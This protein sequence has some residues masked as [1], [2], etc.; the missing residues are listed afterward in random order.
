MSRWDSH[1]YL[2]IAER[3]RNVDELKASSTKICGSSLYHAQHFHHLPLTL[4]PLPAGFVAGISDARLD[5][6]G[7]AIVILSAVAVRSVALAGFGLDSLI[8]IIASLLVVWQ[9]RGVN[10]NSERQALR[11]IGAAFIVPQG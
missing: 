11:L 2:I 3:Q 8:E 4:Q 1:V 7:S 5:V 10:Q 9:L 6:A